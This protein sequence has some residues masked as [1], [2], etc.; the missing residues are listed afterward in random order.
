[1]K[2]EEMDYRDVDVVDPS[3]GID[4]YY[5]FDS[6]TYINI[7]DVT[8]NL[9]GRLDG[10]S[11]CNFDSKIEQ[12]LSRYHWKNIIDNETLLEDDY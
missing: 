12:V 9:E 1:M 10:G 6:H 8:L 3:Y 2:T 11:Y 5:W 7:D 4:Q